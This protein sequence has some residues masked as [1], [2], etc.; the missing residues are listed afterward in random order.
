MCDVQDA[1][2]NRETKRLYD[3]ACEPV[4]AAKQTQAQRP[5]V[6]CRGNKDVVIDLSSNG[7]GSKRAASK[8]SGTPA[9]PK[10]KPRGA[11]KRK[12]PTLGEKA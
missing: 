10:A 1:L 4:A 5:R 7:S 3:E 9:A 12:Y 6:N 8:A 11:E 2:G